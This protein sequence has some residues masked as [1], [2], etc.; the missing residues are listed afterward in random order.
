M[1][2]LKAVLRLGGPMVLTQ[3]F[4]MLTGL[5]DSA[6]AGHYSST[7]LAGV[8]L[9]G[10]I[11]WPSFMLLTGLTMALTPICSQLRGARKLGEVGIKYAKV[12]GFACS[13]VLCWSWF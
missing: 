5:M 8:S 1:T 2:E 7:D 13:P 4:I 10:M 6:M 3:L 12:C 9:G 11:L